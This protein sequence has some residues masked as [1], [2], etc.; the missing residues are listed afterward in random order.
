M[1]LTLKE[2][3][4]ELLG[5]TYVC[6]FFESKCDST[7]L[8][9]VDW[10]HGY[11]GTNCKLHLEFWLSPNPHVVQGATV[12]AV[13]PGAKSSLLWF[14]LFNWKMRVITAV[15]I[16]C[17]NQGKNPS[18]L[19]P[20]RR[21]TFQCKLLCDSSHQ[22]RWCY[23]DNPSHPW[24]YIWNADVFKCVMTLVQDLV[25]L[26]GCLVTDSGFLHGDFFNQRES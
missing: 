22:F 20:R 23:L 8:S 13:W 18:C 4:Y 7:I 9:V 12:L 24:K 6:T 1:Q 2:Q 26:F 3:V 10:I 25:S 19:V 5:P 15:R 21:Q 11:R 16:A 17:L 14:M